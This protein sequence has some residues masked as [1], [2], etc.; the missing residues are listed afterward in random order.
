[1]PCPPPTRCGPTRWRSTRPARRSRR[2]AA[3]ARPG[4]AAPSTRSPTSATGC[5]AT[6]WS[7]LFTPSDSAGKQR[8]VLSRI[9]AR[10]GA[11]SYHLERNAKVPQR[12]SINYARGD[13]ITVTMKDRRQDADAAGVDRVDIRGKVDGIQLEASADTT[14]PPDSTPAGA[15]GP[16]P[17]SSPEWIGALG[18]RDPSVAHRARRDH[19]GGRTERRGPVRRP[20]HGYREAHL[21]CYRHQ[22][23]HAGAGDHRRRDPRPPQRL[24]AA[25]A[26]HRGLDPRYRRRRLGPGPAAGR[27]VGHRG[28]GPPGRSTTRCSAPPAGRPSAP[29]RRRRS[30]PPPACWRASTWPR[31]SRAAGWSTT[32]ASGCSRARSSACWARTARERPRPSTL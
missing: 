12:P 28:R 31:A 18:D 7:P 32:S 15:T 1:M 4:S 25:A 11:Q 21:A 8:A 16:A 22:R 2:S 20:G 6:P 19:A 3:S 9:E 27:L 17:M 13:A 14:A 24:R 5:A 23:D 10:V 30:A 26:G 29:S